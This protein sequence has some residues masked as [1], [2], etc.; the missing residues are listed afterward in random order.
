V[1]VL[2]VLD[3]T[4]VE[5][6]RRA[7]EAAGFE[8][9]AAA[10]LRDAEHVAI[11]R[12]V[13]AVVFDPS[14]VGEDVR[15]RMRARKPALPLVAWLTASSARRTAELFAAGADEVLNGGMGDTELVARAIAAVR[16]GAA[17]AASAVEVG[18]LRIDPVLGEATWRNQAL[19]LTGR[20]REVLLALAESPGRPIPRDVL[21]RKVWG[22]AMARGDRT[23]DVNVKRL[24]AK[25][26][27][28][29]GAEIMITTQTGVGYR[30]E[31]ATPIEA[32]TPL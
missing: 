32:V 2:V 8:T 20:E 10:G 17:P 21:Y 26:A 30:L 16:R 6:V 3:H 14:I 28:A 22:Y 23:V 27:A 31:I 4:E 1:H 15:A 29:I 7:F 25:L 11:A 12:A 24:R 13:D 9:V 18:P 5:R 19:F